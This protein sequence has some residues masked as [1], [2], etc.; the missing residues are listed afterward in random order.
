MIYSLAR[1]CLVMENPGERP[2][3]RAELHPSQDRFQG[4]ARLCAVG[5]NDFYELSPWSQWMPDNL[6]APESLPSPSRLTPAEG[7]PNPLR[8]WDGSSVETADEWRSRRRELER[9]FRHYVYGY[10]PEPAAVDWTIDGETEVLDGQATL[11]EVEIAF[12]EL[13]ADAPSIHLAVFLPK[14]SDDVP[15]V[16]GL[17]WKGN[18]ATVDDPAVT[19]PPAGGQFGADERG[20]T[21]HRW[22]LEQI[23]ERGYAF[24][25]YHSADID[26]D[27]DDFTD[28]IH[29]YYEEL[30]GPTGTEWGTIAA[31]AWGLQRCVDYLES[32]G[33]IDN[34]AIAV[35]G[36]SRRGK[37]ALLAGATDERIDAVVPI[38][39]GTAGCTL[40]RGNNQET[41]ADITSSF[42]H[43]FNDVFHGFSSRPNRLPIDQHLLVAMVAPRPLIGIEGSRDY[44]VNPA[45]A[46]ES[47]RAA[48]PVYDLLNV[49]G[50]VGNGVI[51][52]ND[53]ITAE[54]AGRLLQ[55]REETDHTITPSCW[56]VV[57]DF[58]DI[59]LKYPHADT[60]NGEGSFLNSNDNHT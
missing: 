19:I 17:N 36:K 26:P 6:P 9:L 14:G 27:R 54:S 58:L 11:R 50:M 23:L 22:C 25:T 60:R 8:R 10:T 42:P 53:E 55:Y 7:L 35:T 20:E 40:S 1:H 59:H 33:R 46:L 48:V 29:P 13:P 3:S 31:W 2:L 56:D 41:I 38:M 4:I 52:E 47:L 34:D 51:H 16:L 44:W 45:L 28:G 18:H 21:T 5:T 57:L 24:A 39:S 43:W 49:T 37:T 15:A 30:P 12:P 32:A